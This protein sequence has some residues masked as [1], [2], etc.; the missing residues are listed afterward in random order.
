MF[1]ERE[2]LLRLMAGTE[3]E[4]KPA[5]RRSD[6]KDRL[7]AT[8]LPKVT[9]PEALAAFEKLLAENGF[10]SELSEGWMLIDR[11]PEKL[12]IIA[13]KGPE[14]EA[15]AAILQRHKE[16]SGGETEWREL[17]KA[18]EQA[19]DKQEEAFGRFHAQLAEMLREHKQ[20]PDILIRWKDG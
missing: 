3:T 4:R 6:R 14:A 2:N 20:L 18:C 1:T 12:E 13:E 19:P 9:T 16:K 8:D 10:R 11:V 7:F 15:C 17:Y 5:L